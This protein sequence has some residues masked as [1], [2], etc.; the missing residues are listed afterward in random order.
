MLGK[1]AI[2]R[3][4]LYACFFASPIVHA[5]LTSDSVPR[6]RLV[7]ASE[8]IRTDLDSSPYHL[9]PIRLQPLLLFRDLGYNSNVDASPEN[10]IGDWTGTVA[11]GARWTVPF[12]SKM[13]LR[14]NALPE[15]TW[16][17]ELADRRFLG[18][19]YDA[20]VM[21]LFNRLSMQAYAGTANNLAT[22]SSEIDAL[23]VRKRDELR[24]DA[25]VDIL[26]R[27][28]VFGTVHGQTHDYEDFEDLDR[29][30]Q[31]VKAGIRY[32]FRPHLDFSIA[33]EES[34]AEFVTDPQ[35]RDNTSSATI[36]A[37]H[38]DREHFLANLS[39][40]AREGKPANGSTFPAFDTNTGSYFLSYSL[41]AP[42]EL[43]AY[44]H[45]YVIYGVFADNPYFFE[46]RFGG[47]LIFHVGRRISVRASGS[48]GKNDYPVAVGIGNV[49][50]K[51][52]DDVVEYGGGLSLLVR[53]NVALTLGLTQTDYTS[54]LE[55]FERSVTR[56]QTGI[57]ITGGR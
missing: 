44:G 5:Q 10:P 48:T 2:R 7:P 42:V 4:A 21:A 38:Y 35:E 53:R 39:I 19:T 57:T 13:Y 43:Q 22:V 32:K 40:G 18:G 24:F 36:F 37:V 9:G 54:N 26:R 41:S 50:A 52:V 45:R 14:G 11:A 15:Y 56:I 20:A 1:F 28:S 51:R 16:Y 55:D 23:S 31:L 30:E 25:E 27:L 12:G 3:W 33:R 17:K 47:A 29:D 6:E 34:E 49:S 46:D 8:Q